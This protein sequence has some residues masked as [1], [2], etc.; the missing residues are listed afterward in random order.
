MAGNFINMMTTTNP[1]IQE[2]QQT[3]NWHARF[4]KTI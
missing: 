3:P 4:F 1:Q 2:F